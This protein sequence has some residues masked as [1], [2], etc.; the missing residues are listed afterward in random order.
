MTFTEA[1]EAVLRKTGKPLHYKK[2]TQLAIEQNLLSHVGKTPE[3]TMSTRLATLAKKDRGEAAIVRMKPGI[4]GLRDWGPAAADAAEA[5]VVEGEEAPPEAEEAAAEVEGDDEAV[6]A[7]AN[8]P[9]EQERAQRLAAAAQ[10]FPREADDDEPVMREKP[11]LR[12]LRP[13]SRLPQRPR[14]FD[15]GACCRRTGRCRGGNWSSS[16]P[17]TTRAR[18]W[19]RTHGC[20]R[21]RRTDRRSRGLGARGRHRRR[22]RRADCWARR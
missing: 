13:Y 17:S 1:A 7:T 12:P 21:G 16:A 18:A 3:V 8:T 19:R 14:G 11:P 20:K 15:W 4:F 5:E 9:E 22:R 10:L 6:E 2:I